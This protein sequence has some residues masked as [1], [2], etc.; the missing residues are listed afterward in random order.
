[1]ASRKR[2]SAGLV[3]YRKWQETWQVL[4]AHPGGPI[5]Q[6][7]DEGYWTI[8]KGEVEEGEDLLAVAQ[9][10]FQE[11]IG[12]PPAGPYTPLG[13]IQQKGGKV[14][15]AWAAPAWPVLCLQEAISARSN[16]FQME[17]PP[18]SGQFQDFPEIDR[19]EFFSIPRAIQKI[20]ESQRPLLER[21]QPLLTGTDGGTTK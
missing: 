17:W 7:R 8:P 6:A 19:A 12:C 11:E 5:F 15:H 2:V 10:E 9:R 14:V 21:L 20:K 1:M 13:S 16:T 18:R 4:L 3:V